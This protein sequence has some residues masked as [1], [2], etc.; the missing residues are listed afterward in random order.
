MFHFS[1]KCLNVVYFSSLRGLTQSSII[2]FTFRGTCVT[3]KHLYVLHKGPIS[4]QNCFYDE[5]KNLVFPSHDYQLG[6]PGFSEIDE[7]LE[8]FQT[9]FEKIATIFFRL[10]MTPLIL[11]QQK[12]QHFFWIGNDPP[13]F[14]NFPKINRFLKIQASLTG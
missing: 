8:N 7:F 13:P 3:I 2:L 11:M 5:H 14:G 12:L 6:K 4:S 10:E 1:L 9:A